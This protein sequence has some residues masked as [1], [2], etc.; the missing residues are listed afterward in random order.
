MDKFVAIGIRI[1][2][3]H[4]DRKSYSFFSYAYFFTKP[5]NEG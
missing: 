2:N 1:Q 4:R 5:N 3:T